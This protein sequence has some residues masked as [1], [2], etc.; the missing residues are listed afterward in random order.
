MN[1][2]RVVVVGW[3]FQYNTQDFLVRLMYLA[4][5]GTVLYH[6][7]ARVEAG[8]SLTSPYPQSPDVM[9]HRFALGGV[10]LR[11]MVKLCTQPY[12]CPL[13]ILRLGIDHAYQTPK[14]TTRCI[15]VMR[16]KGQK[17]G[18]YGCVHGPQGTSS[19]TRCCSRVQ[20]PL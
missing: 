13:P 19:K 4:E 16:Q 5:D 9:P 3:V 17:V 10:N 11:C 12:A 2:A 18:E 14:C 8:G 7:P 20:G 15:W 1:Q 6:L